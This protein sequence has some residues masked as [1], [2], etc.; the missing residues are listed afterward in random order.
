MADQ[1]KVISREKTIVRT[2]I[3][4][5][6]ANIL[7]ASF[8]ALVGLAVHS[9]AMVLDAVN[10]FSDVLSSVVTIIGTKIAARKPD[11]KHPLGHGRVEY[12]SQM[13]V[14][15][16]IIYAGITALWESIKK[17]INPV[18]AEHSAVSLA[19]IS[20]A[21]VV[22]I[23]LG[24][25]VKAKGKEVKSN[26]LISSGTDALFDAVL[27]TAVLI[28]AVIFMAFKFNIEAYVSVVISIFILKA[29]IEI[30]LEA[31][32]DMLGHRVEGEYTRN[33]KA[34]AAAVPGVYGVYDI[35]L[36][37]YGP[38]RYLGSLHIEVD[39]TVTADRIDQLTREINNKVFV[40]T[41]VILT[42][43]GIYSRNTSNDEQ[44]RI[45]NEITKLVVEHDH[46]LQLHGFYIDEARKRVT[47]DVVIDF[48]ASDREGLFEHI[49]ED[50]RKVLPEYD[51]IVALDSD[52]SDQ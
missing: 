13:I 4:G 6:A 22:K 1:D 7:L 19:V 50:V 10:N 47:F 18:D 23:I 27:S 8:K 26:L 37:N 49:K 42:A 34:S 15:A 16:L 20:V 43:V 45:R 12:L 39:D 35:V 33:V 38:D 24:L 29:G 28:S 14:A 17:I 30:I 21:I 36:H 31:V 32:D 9:T 44:M 3:I 51:V 48:E 5:I 41:G 25:Y 52:I 2:G 40:E 11:K 46:V